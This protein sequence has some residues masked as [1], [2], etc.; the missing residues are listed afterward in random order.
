MAAPVEIVD[1]NWHRS[2]QLHGECEWKQ[3]ESAVM[4]VGEGRKAPPAGSPMGMIAMQQEAAYG[5]TEF[6]RP[7]SR[8][9]LRGKAGAG[10]F[11][12]RRRHVTRQQKALACADAAGSPR[13]R[14]AAPLCIPCE[15]IVATADG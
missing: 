10:G 6:G 1:S 9:P 4:D 8:F 14:A 12:P 7:L 13:K 5:S 11:P 15:R 3:G 2:K